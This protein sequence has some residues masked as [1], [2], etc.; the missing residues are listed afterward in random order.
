MYQNRLP[1]FHHVISLIYLMHLR[2]GLRT[3]SGRRSRKLPGTKILVWTRSRRFSRF[4]KCL[5]CVSCE[6]PSPSFRPC[7]SKTS[8]TSSLAQLAASRRHSDLLICQLGS[9]GTS[10]LV[11][12]RRLQRLPPPPPLPAA[13]WQ[14]DWTDRSW[15]ECSPGGGGV[16]FGGKGGLT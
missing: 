12:L 5:S 3:A 1:A 9:R 6:P 4:S 16:V 14:S 11:V 10:S 15:P 7:S 2:L 13:E 8:L